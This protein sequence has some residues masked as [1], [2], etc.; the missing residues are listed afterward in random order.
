M[1]NTL[2]V[3]QV[4]AH[5]TFSANV[6]HK[7]AVKL[8]DGRL[9]ALASAHGLL[10][11]SDW[12]GADFTSLARHQ[13]EPYT[14]DDPARL[15]MSGESVLLPADVATPFGLV[16]HELAT[17]AAKHGSLSVPAGKIELRSTITVQNDQRVFT[18]VWRERDGPTVRPA[19]STGLGTALIRSAIPNAKVDC[20]YRPDGLL[21]TIE[22]PLP[23]EA[24]VL[25]EPG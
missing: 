16:L 25:N 7:E 14:S 3:V 1:R 19:K 18:V 8:F 4:I 9:A 15:V 6:A 17:N 22:V 5:Q 21:C 24:G 23:Q 12:K 2:T 10:V 13:L 11:Q 20:E